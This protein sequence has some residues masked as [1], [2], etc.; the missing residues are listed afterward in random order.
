MNKKNGEEKVKLSRIA[1]IDA[2]I[3]SGRYPNAETLAAELEVSPRTILRDIE[4]L[5]IT[6]NAPIEYDFNERGFY[7]TEPTF[8]IRSVMLSKEELETITLFDQFSKITTREEDDFSVKL[9]KIIDK[10][11]MVL[12]EEQTNSLP[13]SPTPGQHDFTFGGSVQIDGMISNEIHLAMKNKE[14]IEI[15]HWISDNKKYEKKEIEPLHIFFQ[16][17]HY[18]LLAYKNDNHEKPGIYSINRI[19]KVTNTGKKFEIPDDFRLKDYIEK[20]VDVSPADNKLYHFEFSFPKEIASEVIDK[21][22][23]HNQHIELREDGTVYLEFRSTQLYGV[24][25]WVLIE[26]HKV[27]VINPPELVRMIRREAQ[28]VAQYYV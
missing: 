23:Y 22:Y 12:P 28:K 19:R 16:R 7:Y 18:Y 14:V 15:E 3:H 26:G 4:Y 11:L 5:R 2:E 20:K 9:R 21:T 27:K 10:L 6:Y 25:D 17:H 1:R 24:F 8:F 13:F